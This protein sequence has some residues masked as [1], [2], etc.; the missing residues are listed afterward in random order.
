V[1]WPRSTARHVLSAAP[2]GTGSEAYKRQTPPVA[3]GE[4]GRRPKRAVG[5]REDLRSAY[6]APARISPGTVT[7]G[8]GRRK[9]F[10]EIAVR[11]ERKL[12]DALALVGGRR[13]GASAR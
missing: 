5:V 9:P 6:D 11:I 1:P 12:E 10:Y 3:R 7:F 8:A 13:A 2:P 4:G